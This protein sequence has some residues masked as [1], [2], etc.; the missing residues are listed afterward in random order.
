MVEAYTLKA[1]RV[2]LSKR[3]AVVQPV[4]ERF[5]IEFIGGRGWGAKIL[6]DEFDGPIH[7]FSP[8]NLLI[9]AGGPLT[10]LTV[11]CSG[12]TAFVSIS[13]LTGLYGDSNV[14]GSLA[15]E[16]KKNGFDVLIV[17]GAAE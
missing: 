6:Y 8:E 16:L 14:G 4:N 2:N 15:V 11:P 10:G 5:A 13:P 3:K 12:K 7:A 1:L 9:V 17:E